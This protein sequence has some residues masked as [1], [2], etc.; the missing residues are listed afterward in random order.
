MEQVNGPASSSCCSTSFSVVLCARISASRARSPSPIRARSSDQGVAC[1]TTNLGMY[2]LDSELSHIARLGPCQELCRFVR[3][4]HEH[5][6]NTEISEVAAPERVNSRPQLPAG[7]CLGSCRKSRWG[8]DTR[9]GRPCRPLLV[10]SSFP[11]PHQCPASVKDPI[12]TFREVP[13]RSPIP[14]LDTSDEVSAHMNGCPKPIL[15]QSARLTPRPKL[16]TEPV[17]S[18]SVGIQLTL[19]AAHTWLIPPLPPSRPPIPSAIPTHRP[20]QVSAV[21]GTESSIEPAPGPSMLLAN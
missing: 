21:V 8:G 13:S 6:L 4:G 19:R 9:G 15:R 14:G 7:G 3:S 10:L 1:D 5:L 20:R 2:L 17:Q 11:Q 12:A 16:I 18:R